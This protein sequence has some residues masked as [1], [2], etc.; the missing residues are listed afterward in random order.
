M[1]LET[2]TY[3]SDLNTSNPAHSDGLDDADSHI[4]LIK[5]VL[6]NTFA[7][8]GAI[9]TAAGLSVSPDG[10]AAAPSIAFTSEPTLGFYR[11]AAGQI[12]V[13]GYLQGTVDI[14]CITDFAGPDAQIPTGW[15]ACDGTALSRTTF[16]KLF[17]KI[18]TTWGAGDGSTT[19]NIPNLQSRY[20]RHRDSGTLAGAVGTLQNPCNLTHTHTFSAT[21]S[22]EGTLHSHTFSGSTGGTST[23][24][25]FTATVNGRTYGNYTYNGSFATTGVQM[26]NGV[27]GT[28]TASG[29]MDHTH[30]YSGTT[31]SESL[32]HTHSV[33]GTTSAGAGDNAN[34]AR[35][36][37]ATVTTIIR[38]F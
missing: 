37:S 17:T 2:A 12:G 28:V 7:V 27:D 5:S 30:A 25:A 36:Y 13:A 8:T 9:L 1:P 14:G 26:Q 33:S 16:A 34:E 10:S 32:A 19:F 20:R 4:R 35:P 18:S 21:T 22:T 15:M 29:N 38:V 11:A 24:G 31:S 3:I 6:K 23:G